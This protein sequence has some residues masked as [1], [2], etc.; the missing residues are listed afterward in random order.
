M[1]LKKIG[2]NKNNSMLLPF[3]CVR[4]TQILVFIE[5]LIVKKEGGGGTC[6]LMDSRKIS[7]L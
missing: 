1:D 6:K 4:L 7:A 5:S 3:D 2:V